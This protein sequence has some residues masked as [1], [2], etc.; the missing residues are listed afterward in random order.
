MSLQSE[1]PA[2][3]YDKIEKRLKIKEIYNTAQY[4]V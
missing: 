1:R 2:Q 4:M 3:Q